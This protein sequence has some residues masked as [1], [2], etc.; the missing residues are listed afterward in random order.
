M[1]RALCRVCGVV[2]NR[3]GAYRQSL[4]TTYKGHFREQW[5]CSPCVTSLDGGRAVMISR[6]RK[7]PPR[8]A[9]RR[10]FQTRNACCR[11]ASGVCV[12]CRECTSSSLS[13]A[14]SVGQGAHARTGDYKSSVARVLLTLSLSLPRL[15][16]PSLVP[17][18][19]ASARQ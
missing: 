4:Q 11:N 6:A 5:Y 10:T 16:C 15:Q 18:K 13:R 1:R 17:C 14:V 2:D 12:H 19:G 8:D 9:S 3:C 7:L